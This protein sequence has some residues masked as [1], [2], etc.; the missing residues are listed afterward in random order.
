MNR[1][2]WMRSSN[3]AIP[4]DP[5]S[6]AGSPVEA[7]PNAITIIEQTSG[8]AP[9]PSPIGSLEADI[10]RGLEERLPE[11]VLPEIEIPKVPSGQSHYQ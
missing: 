4:N 7:I 11:P 5:E 1:S 9:Y 6:S 8:E 2:A 10:L 3:P